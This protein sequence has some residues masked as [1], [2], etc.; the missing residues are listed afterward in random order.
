[1][2]EIPILM[3]TPMVQAN[4]ED[5]KN[6]TRRTKGLECIQEIPFGTGLHRAPYQKED[7][8]WFYEVQTKVDDS[9]VCE[10]KCPYGKPGDRLWVRE[11]WNT[12]TAY[13]EKPDYSVM[14][15]RDFVY[16]ADGNRIDKW[17]PSIFMPREACRI[18]L[19]VTDVRVER[20]RDISEED[21]I[22]EGIERAGYGWRSYE[23]IH[24]GRH[25]GEANPHSLVPNKSPITSY[26][27]LW[28]AINGLGSWDKNPWVWVITFRRIQS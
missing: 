20:L 2:R 28:E 3:S 11:T 18:L 26:M 25:K 9:E 4:L 5:R 6:Q 17:K 23:I 8:G 21:A 10:L 15:I 7:M 19:E 22:A 24:K 14:S 13:D 12:L 27:E 1:M 16:K